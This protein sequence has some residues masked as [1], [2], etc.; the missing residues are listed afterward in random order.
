MS[1]NESAFVELIR[2]IMEQGYD[3]ET[4]GRYAVLIGDLPITDPQGKIVVMSGNRILA[5]LEPLKFFE[6]EQ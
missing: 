3:R 2:E 5:R 4:A 6:A 1:M